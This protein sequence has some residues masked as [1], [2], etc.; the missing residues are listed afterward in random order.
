M[1]SLATKLTAGEVVAAEQ[2]ITGG[3]Q[4]IRLNN[5]GEATGGTVTLNS[6]LVNAL[7]SSVGGSI[8]ALTITHGVKVVDDVSQLSISGALSNY[9]SIQTASST[10]GSTDTISAGSILN[11]SG[12]AIGSYTGKTAGLYAA[13]PSLSAQSTLTNN[14]SISSVGNLTLSAPVVTNAPVNGSGGTITAAQNVNVNTQTLNNSGAI[15]ALTGNVNVAS[16]SSLAVNNAGGTVQAESGNI[17]LNTNNADI[18]VSGGNFYSQEVNLKAGKATV[19]FNVDNAS[20]VINA[21][22][23][24]YI[25]NTTESA[26]NLGN[27]DSTRRPRFLK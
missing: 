18:N 26:L 9:G 25:L 22:G 7:D 21:S 12:G 23:N 13:D 11:A 10:A 3:R 8:G 6:N 5:T 17:N 20:G 4:T 24:M 16:T 27:V 14:G 1:V 2:V 19:L 15:A